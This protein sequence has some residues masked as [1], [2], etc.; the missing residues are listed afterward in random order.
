[1]QLRFLLTKKEFEAIHQLKPEQ[2]EVYIEALFDAEDESERG[3]LVNIIEEL[4]GGNSGRVII[5]IAAAQEIVN[6]ITRYVVTD[7]LYG[8]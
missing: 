7:D 1:M 2:G 4:S 5:D 6:S 8:F 3:K